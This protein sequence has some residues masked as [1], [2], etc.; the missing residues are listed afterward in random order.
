MQ[1][2]DMPVEDSPKDANLES[3]DKIFCLLLDRSVNL[4]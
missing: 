4:Q 1:E 3:E 2:K